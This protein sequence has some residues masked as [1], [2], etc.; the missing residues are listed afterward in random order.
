MSIVNLDVVSRL[1]FC[2]LRRNLET[3]KQSAPLAN[4]GIF[5]RPSRMRLDVS[6]ILACMPTATK[7][8]TC[9]PM[10]RPTIDG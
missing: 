2:H 3:S 6:C 7:I 10:V 8:W 5:F 1:Q 9:D 4:D